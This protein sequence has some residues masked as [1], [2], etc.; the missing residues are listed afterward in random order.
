MTDIHA[1]NDWLS[2]LEISQDDL[3]RVAERLERDEAPQELKAI[4]LRV[5]QAH[6]EPD[7]DNVDEQAEG[8]LFKHGERILGRLAEKLR[9]ESRF[10]GLEDKWF[11]TDKLP[12]ID[13]DALRRV[14]R[15]LLQNPS[16]T[17]DEV[18]SALKET[19][20]TDKTILRMALH[21]ALS[22]SPERFENMGTPAHPQWKARLP[23]IEQAEVIHYAYDPQTYEVLC[24]PGQRLSQKKAK[25]LQELN[26]YVHVVTFAE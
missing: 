26:L 14:H 5:V 17:L 1:E 2:Q 11:L 24:R 8:I 19:G 21:S 9:S 20:S 6:M 23:E 15:L 10:T 16:S 13:G 12:Q 22:R 18:L 4:A 25:R 3:Q 7:S